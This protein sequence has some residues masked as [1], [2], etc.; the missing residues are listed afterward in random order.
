MPFKSTNKT[1]QEE[2][3]D[4]SA[5][6]VLQT[7][8]VAEQAVVQSGDDEQQRKKEKMRVVV[9]IDGSEGSF[10][11][12]KWALDLLLVGPKDNADDVATST[13]T[14]TLEAPHAGSH[15]N[16]SMV[17]LVY[18]MQPFQNYVLSAAVSGELRKEQEERATAILAH[19]LEICK[20]KKIKAQTL[21][22]SGDP[23]DMICQ[24]TEQM[25]VDLLVVGSRGL[26]MV[27]RT[28]IGSVSDY[29]AHHAKCPVVI[30]KPPKE[31]GKQ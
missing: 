15:E 10:Y 25:H 9:A 21:I 8:I 7:T 27:K 18:V 29:C 22:L 19:A 1:T 13:G 12:L 26:G 28:F 20:D 6:Q 11:A 16:V 24:A 5:K 4:I 14:A 30:V 31:S 3:E 17:T 23:N 2:E